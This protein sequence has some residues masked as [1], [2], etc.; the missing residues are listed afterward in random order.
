[1]TRSLAARGALARRDTT[2]AMRLLAETLAQAVSGEQGMLLW[3]DAAAR[4]P[5]RLLYAQLLAA[6]REF[7]RAMDVADVF[8]S[9]AAQSYVAFVPA[10]LQLRAA[11]ADSAHDGARS[12]AYRRRLLALSR[13]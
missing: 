1:M 11:M 10:S 5:E 8:D 7:T 9:P 12:A 13:H 3:R 4:G 2:E 6:R